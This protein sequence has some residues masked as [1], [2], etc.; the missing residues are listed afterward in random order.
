MTPE[1]FQKVLELCDL[2][3]VGEDGLKDLPGK[4][5]IT[6][7]LSCNS[8]GLTIPSIEAIAVDG[9][10]SL[11]ART[12]KGDLYAC[13]PADVFAANVEGR[14]KPKAQRRAGFG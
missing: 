4:V 9:P 14:A 7:Y 10:T 5:T 11:R 12:T 8:V 1:A 13:S 3:P 2:G 6:L